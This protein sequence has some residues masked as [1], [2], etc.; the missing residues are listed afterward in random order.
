[1]TERKKRNR[2]VS[3]VISERDQKGSEIIISDAIYYHHSKILPYKRKAIKMIDTGLML[4]FTL[5]D[6]GFEMSKKVANNLFSLV[7]K[8]VPE[9]REAN[10]NMLR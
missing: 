3:E 6:K 5:L 7:S 1:M 9:K 2:R 10:A 8:S 4:S